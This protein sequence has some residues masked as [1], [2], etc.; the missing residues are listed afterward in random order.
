MP[1]SYAIAR[2]PSVPSKMAM[3]LPHSA[4]IC[5][6]CYLQT[7]MKSSPYQGEWNNSLP[8][9]YIVHI[10]NYQ[11]IYS[12]G[13]QSCLSFQKGKMLPHTWVPM[14]RP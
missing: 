11:C 5:P 1:F 10:N 9:R 12:S 3:A 6:E 14:L 7:F 2:E 13:A 8:S 4:S